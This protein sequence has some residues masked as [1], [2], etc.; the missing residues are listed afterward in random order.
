MSIRII[1]DKHLYVDNTFIGFVRSIDMKE[2]SVIFHMKDKSLYKYEID[3]IQIEVI[4]CDILSLYIKNN[5]YRKNNKVIYLTKKH[6]EINHLVFYK[7]A[8]SII[9]K[10]TWI[11]CTIYKYNI[12]GLRI[13]TIRFKKYCTIYTTRYMS[14]SKS[15][16]TQFIKLFQKNWMFTPTTVYVF[17][18]NLG[19]IYRVSEIDNIWLL[20]K[21]V[22]VTYTDTKK[23][24]PPTR[25][26]FLIHAKMLYFSNMPWLNILKMIIIMKN[27][28]SSII[29]III[30]FCNS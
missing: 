7:N 16:I 22:Y 4:L 8:P 3:D 12:L 27:N 28:M 14:L 11:D 2:N 15:D 19:R 6:M 10:G 26:D 21:C 25:F 13:Y 5:I 20:K 29:S 30:F 18:N 23:D 24:E 1:N 9:K 17:Y